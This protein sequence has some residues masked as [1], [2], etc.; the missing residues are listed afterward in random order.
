MLRVA[1]LLAA[2]ALAS[3]YGAELFRLSYFDLIGYNPIWNSSQQVGDMPILNA[4]LLTYGAPI[5]WSAWLVKELPARGV[6]HLSRYVQGF[7]LLLAFILVSYQV[8][9]MFHGSVLDQ[10]VS[11]NAEIY[12]Y[13]VAWLLLGLGLLLVGT[14][15]VDKLMR[16]ASLLLMI[17]TVGKVFL[18]D[19]SELE[20]LYRV[21][22][23]LGLGISL[24]GL[25]WF[26][27]RFVFGTKNA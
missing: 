16:V 17:L 21:F 25:S 6:A 14:A 1:L 7:M 8:T 19:A 27:T 4:L 9:Q 18:Y 15:R 5:L 11:T 2:L 20:G 10:G 12:S 24:L 13:S 22:S 26:Y 23:F 3:V